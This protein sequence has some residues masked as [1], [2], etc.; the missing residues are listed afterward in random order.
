MENPGFYCTNYIKCH[1]Y[2]PKYQPKPC[3]DQCT[4]CMDII[5]DHHFND[6]KEN[7]KKDEWVNL[8][9]YNNTITNG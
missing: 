6:N 3:K 7:N 9:D 8:D 5:I 4:A 1:S 2:L